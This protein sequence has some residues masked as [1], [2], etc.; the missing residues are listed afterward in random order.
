M[1][2]IK[3]K[4]MNKYTFL[5]VAVIF[6]STAV[7]QDNEKQEEFKTLF[8]NGKSTHGGYGGLSINYSQID[9]EDAI[10]VGARGGWIINHGVMIGIGGYGFANDMNYD[11]TID[12]Y[13]D[14]YSL[15]GGYGGLII[16]P[17]IGAKWPVHVTFPILIGAGGVALINNYY[18]E[19][20]WDYYY[21]DESDAFF[22]IEPGIEIEMNMVKFMRLAV[23]G[24]Y[25][26]TSDLYLSDT[27]S[28]VL[29]GFSVGLTMKF[30][31]F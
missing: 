12:G 2:P 29:D 6:V 9:G 27:D 17:I 23:G 19:P 28:H 24:Y 3:F 20:N 14:N 11:K 21:S 26:Y 7:A 31:K 30:G 15:A 10:L 25:R 1:K 4:Q 13:Y 16:E 22:V 8:G 18:G 5:L